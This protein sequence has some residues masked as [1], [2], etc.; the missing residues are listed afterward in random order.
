MN[1]TIEFLKE[2]A[3]QVRYK[4]LNILFVV[5]L[6]IN[7]AAIYASIAN[8][9]KPIF[10]PP[11][12]IAV[13]YT[14]TSIIMSFFYRSKKGIHFWSYKVLLSIDFL[15]LFSAFYFTIYKNSPALTAVPIINSI[16]LIIFFFYLLCS[17]FLLDL[18]YLLC[19]GS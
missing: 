19:I 18:T 17:G 2:Y 12:V 11:F 1:T 15:I 6:I 5:R 9:G 4:G 13:Y 10:Y 16:Y 14:V 8:Y 3:G 7:I